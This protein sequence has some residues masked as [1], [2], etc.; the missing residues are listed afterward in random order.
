M[1]GDFLVCYNTFMDI[2][3]LLGKIADLILNPIIILGFVIATIYF[4]YGIFELI[5]KADEGNDD[6]KKNILYGLV[7]LFVMFSVYG[8]LSLVLDTFGIDK[9][10]L[11]P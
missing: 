9:R 7:G 10:G 3:I 2:K 6:H 4:F 11:L 8:I 1:R 5:W